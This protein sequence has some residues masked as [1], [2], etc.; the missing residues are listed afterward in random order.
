MSWLHNFRIATRPLRRKLRNF[1][2]RRNNLSKLQTVFANNDRPR[3]ILMLTPTHGNLG[4]HDIAMGELKL[5]EELCQD[6]QIIEVSELVYDACKEDLKTLITKQDIIL[7]QGGGFF[8]S[9]YPESHGARREIIDHYRDN[10]IICL[11]VSIYYADDETGYALLQ[12]DK[13]VMSESKKLT[14]MVR[15]E[16]SFALAKKEFKGL[17][18]LLTPDC[19]VALEKDNFIPIKERHCV[20]FVWRRDK[21]KVVDSDILPNIVRKLPK[22]TPYTIIDNVG[23][24][25]FNATTRSIAVEH[26]LERIGAAKVVVTDRF[27]GVVFA[28]ITHTPVIAFPSMDTKIV[29]GIKWFSDLPYVHLVEKLSDAERLLN[30]YLSETTN[31]DASEQNSQKLLESLRKVVGK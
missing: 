2:I 17:D 18:V 14:L 13:M 5:L 22:G 27:H 31:I 16:V 7:I 28:A 11:P 8:G 1:R 12:C 29:A 23:K 30:L 3:F 26:Q 21:E 24:K 6:M 9:L 20:V 4:D 19:A 15:D 25:R 10:K